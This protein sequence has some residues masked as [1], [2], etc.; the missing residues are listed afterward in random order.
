MA[1]TRDAR[2]T[3][4]SNARIR[5]I[6]IPGITDTP[7]DVSDHTYHKFIAEISDNCMKPPQRM[8]AQPLMSTL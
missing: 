1:K 7:V 2:L 6:S 5:L 8:V 4:H 3:Q